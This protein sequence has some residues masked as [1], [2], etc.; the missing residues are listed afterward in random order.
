MIVNILVLFIWKVHNHHED[1]SQLKV[2]RLVE[3]QA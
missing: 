2:D 1:C 3:R